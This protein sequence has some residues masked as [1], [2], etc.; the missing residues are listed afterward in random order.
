MSVSFSP[1]MSNLTACLGSARR[2]VVSL[3]LG[4]EGQI[5]FIRN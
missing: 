4:C 5:V 2:L 1:A 3:Y